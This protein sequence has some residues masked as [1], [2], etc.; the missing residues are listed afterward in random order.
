MD[1]HNNNLT[2][3]PDNFHEIKIDNGLRLDNNQIT[4]LPEDFGKLSI[5]HDGVPGTGGL[6]LTNNL[7]ETL[8]GRFHRNNSTQW[9]LIF[10]F[11]SINKSTRRRLQIRR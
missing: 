10:T 1:L 4:S 3:L 7:L 6:E 5:G 9:R 11:K 2:L 8:P